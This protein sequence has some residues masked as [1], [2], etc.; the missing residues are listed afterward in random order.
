MSEPPS[1]FVMMPF[2]VREKDM[3]TYDG[4]Q[5]HWL[6]VY[7]GLIRPA[8]KQAGLVPVRDDEDYSSRVVTDQIWSK[9]EHAEI[10]LADI[11]SSNPNV[12]LELGWALRA[13]YD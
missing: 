12:F 1:C 10:I 2:S 4:D 13:S 9:I 7:E 5:N 8:V 11:S 3:D 6:E